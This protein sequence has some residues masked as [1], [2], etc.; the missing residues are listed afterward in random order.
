M[1]E[2]APL[3]DENL[4]TSELGEETDKASNVASHFQYKQGDIE[5]DSQRPT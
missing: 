1:K 5:K 2:D 3:L 4:R